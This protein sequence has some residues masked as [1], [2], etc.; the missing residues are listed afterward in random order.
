MMHD[1]TLYTVRAMVTALVLSLTLSPAAA[2]QSSRGGTFLPLG[3]DARGEGLAGAATVLIRD[4]RSAYWNPANLTALTSARFSFG[5]T[6]P[7]PGLPNLYSFFSI[8]TGL[9]DT[10]EVAEGDSPVSEVA[11]ALSITHLGLELS[12]GSG[13]NESSIGASFAYAPNSYNSFGITARYMKSWTD[14]EDGE[15]SGIGVD[16]GWTA[17]LRAKFLLSVMGRNVYNQV[18]YPN[19]DYMLD[20][21]W[22]LAVAYENLFDRASL[23]GDAVF[24]RGELSRLLLGTE[25]TIWRNLLMLLVGADNRLIEG[26]RTVMHFGLVAER[27]AWEIAF[28]Y[29]FDPMDAFGKAYR[30]SFGYSL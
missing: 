4:D 9:F 13:W 30:I 20:P 23:E 21:A 26:Q 10:H 27:N 11:A 15:A 12:G 22:N 17:R 6:R 2:G 16:V 1:R 3:W 8:G 25:V 18:Y 5:A 14:V 19:T 7:V 29:T 28:A 24:R